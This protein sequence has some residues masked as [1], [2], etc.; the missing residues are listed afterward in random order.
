MRV[1]APIIVLRTPGLG[2]GGNLLRKGMRALLDPR[3]RV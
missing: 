1:L 2:I 3:L